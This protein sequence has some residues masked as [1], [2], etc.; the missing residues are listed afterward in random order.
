VRAIRTV[1]VAMADI[2]DIAAT[3]GTATSATLRQWLR[4]Y[5]TTQASE[6]AMIRVWLDATADDPSLQPESAAALDWGRRRM[7]QFLEPRG[8]G[9][10]DTEALVMV[11][12]LDALGARQPGPSTVP[13]T[14]HIIER[15][16]LGR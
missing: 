6:A 12:L 13:A 15:G 16:F 11:A 10:V 1:S 9:D 2:P 5:H 3:P 8:F 4:R 7:A 14:A